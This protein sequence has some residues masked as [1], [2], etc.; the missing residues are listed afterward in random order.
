[1][2]DALKRIARIAPCV[3]CGKR[4]AVV[5]EG[6]GDTAY[7]QCAFDAQVRDLAPLL[8]AAL[9]AIIISDNCGYQRNTM[10]YEGLFDAGREAIRRAT[11]EDLTPG[12]RLHDARSVY[13]ELLE[14]CEA[15][16]MWIDAMIGPNDHTEYPVRSQLRAAIANAN[17]AREQ[18]I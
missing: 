1:M 12:V 4:L 7:C 10:R 14:A 16:L 17:V 3:L 11:G 9:R 2:T 6:K 18:E 5:L 15:A 13:D 8:L